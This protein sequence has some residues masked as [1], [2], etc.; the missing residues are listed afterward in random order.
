MPWLH[1][2]LPTSTLT[3][4]MPWLAWMDPSMLIGNGIDFSTDLLYDSSTMLN[5][6]DRLVLVCISKSL[7]FRL[8]YM[9]PLGLY[10]ETFSFSNYI[11]QNFYCEEL[12]AYL[13][14]FPHVLTWSWCLH[15]ILLMWHNTFVNICKVHD[16]VSL[17]WIPPGYGQWS[18]SC[19][20]GF[21]MLVFCW[22]ILQFCLSRMLTISFYCW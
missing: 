13:I 4:S 7:T 15:F 17:E 3:D 14:S 6:S 2:L 11:V 8:Y 1:F 18:L 10:Y 16:L 5:K 19:D 12:L 21:E 22:R 20:P 9:W